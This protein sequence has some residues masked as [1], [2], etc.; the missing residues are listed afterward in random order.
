MGRVRRDPSDALAAA[1]CVEG[2]YPA[3][4][5]DFQRFYGVDARDVLTGRIGVRRLTSLLEGMPADSALARE[6]LGSDWT[7]DTALLAVIADRLGVVASH[8][9]G[10]KSP[11]D[12]VPRPAGLQ[13]RPRVVTDPAE[14]A[15]FFAGG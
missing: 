8:G 13:P 9:Y 5:A 14:I 12:P 15:A 7:S 10:F 6:V 1:A 11:P 4:E 3:V 2:Y